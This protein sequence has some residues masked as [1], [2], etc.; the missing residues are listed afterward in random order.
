MMMIR[1]RRMARVMMMQAIIR[2]VKRASEFS[3][4]D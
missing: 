1:S 3:L 2:A 4:F